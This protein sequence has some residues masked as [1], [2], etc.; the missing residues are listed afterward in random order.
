LLCAGTSSAAVLD[1]MIAAGEMVNRTSADGQ[2][3]LMFAAANGQVDNIQALLHHGAKADDASA[4]GWTPI[5]F[6]MRGKSLP[7]IQTL[8]SGGADVSH[9]TQ[10][11]DTALQIA[12]EDKNFEFATLLV[13]SGASLNDNWDL[14]GRTPLQAAVLA[15]NS[16]LVALMIAKG[17]DP[18]ELSHLAYGINPDDISY[19]P[20]AGDKRFTPRTPIDYKALGYTPRIMLHTNPDG[21]G[22][23][24]IPPAPVTALL[25]A[26]KTGQVDVMRALVAAGAN[27][28]LVNDD[29][30]NVLL[31][32][33]AS[34]KLEAVQYALQIYPDINTTQRDGS[35]L[36]LIAVGG[37]NG[38]GGALPDGV[39]AEDVLIT[40]KFLIEQGVPID[41]KNNRGQTALSEA[42][43]RGDSKMQALFNQAVADRAAKGK[44]VSEDAARRD[45]SN[46]VE[47]DVVRPSIGPAEAKTVASTPKP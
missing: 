20:P 14:H 1:R 25:L 12:L 39:T 43:D 9:K 21:G 41:T 33:A 18:N 10:D 28:K 22:P 3:A 26:A 44:P 17:A 38:E 4:S 19:H 6:A 47:A 29:G 37:T 46:I 32:A 31:L 8:I 30:I 40:A 7:A 16:E 36:L 35:N 2:N 27:P 42:L 23:V 11:G 45:R 15:H 24:R 34:H 13:N 5:M